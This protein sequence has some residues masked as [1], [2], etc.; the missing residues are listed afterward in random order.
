MDRGLTEEKPKT[1]VTLSKIF[2]DLFP[3]YL[4]MGMSPEEYWDGDSWLAKGYRE[5][6]KIRMETQNR[7]ADRDA[8]RIGQYIQMALVS[9]PVTVNG[10]AP[11][12]HRLHE[13]PEKPYSETY[14]E[15]KRKESRKKQE[16]KQQ[17]LAQ[18]MFQAFTEKMNKG[19][20]K[21]LEQEKD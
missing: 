19:I 11:K 16:E 17:V 6:Y 13:Y 12:G 21:R 18:A 1:P 20:R 7:I 2:R 14:E 9:V 15:N 10:F 4:V 8:W 5:A 3:Q